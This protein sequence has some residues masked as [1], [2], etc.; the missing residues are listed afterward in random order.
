MLLAIPDDEDD[1]EFQGRSCVGLLEQ[2]S[3]A[4]CLNPVRLIGVRDYYEA[5]FGG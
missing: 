4:A 2:G 1:L 5:T 3:A